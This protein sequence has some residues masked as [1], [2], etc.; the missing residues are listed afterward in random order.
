MVGRTHKDHF[1]NV[2][3]SKA[4]SACKRGETHKLKLM[5]M[6]RLADRYRQ[7]DS[8]INRQTDKQADLQADRKTK[9]VKAI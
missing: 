8:E 2:E 9:S 6:Y 3:I 4:A 7:T 5:D 1:K